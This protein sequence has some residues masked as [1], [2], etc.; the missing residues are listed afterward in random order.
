MQRELNPYL[1]NF[2]KVRDARK[3]WSESEWLLNILR[4]DTGQQPHIP[5][6][7]ELLQWAQKLR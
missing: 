5:T 1:R 2:D 4:S 3:K 7:E 6:D